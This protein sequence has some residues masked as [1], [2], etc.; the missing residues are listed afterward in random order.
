MINEQ[1]WVRKQK[2]F[3]IS[4]TIMFRFDHLPYPHIANKT[5]SF[6]VTGRTQP[7]SHG[8]VHKSGTPQVNHGPRISIRC[9]FTRKLIGSLPFAS[10]VTLALSP[11]TLS[12]LRCLWTTD[13]PE[14]LVEAGPLQLGQTEEEILVDTCCVRISGWHLWNPGAVSQDESTL[15]DFH[16]A[17]IIIFC[18]SSGASQQH[19]RIFHT[20]AVRRGASVAQ[21]EWSVGIKWAPW[22]ASTFGGLL[23]RLRFGRWHDL[24][25][26]WQ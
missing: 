9:T 1:F 12:H 8:D 19:Q 23:L 15:P 16:L 10:Q 21:G 13:S 5:T 11:A 14:P 17:P 24:L 7:A 18:P 6:G 2:L 3:G 26:L 22:T 4:L 20:F 25:S